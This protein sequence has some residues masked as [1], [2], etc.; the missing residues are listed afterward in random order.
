VS[1]DLGFVHVHRPPQDDDPLTLLLL[2]GTGADERDLLPLGALLA[3]TARKLSPRGKVLEHGM[4]RWFRRHAEGV[5][6]TEDLIARSHELADL[7]PAAAA[8]YGF[9]R[10]AVVAAGFSN[11]ANIAGATM[12]LRPEAFRAA[13]LFAPM[14]PLTVEHLPSL[15]LP[16]L[17]TA[18]VFVAAGR[19]DP[20]CPPEQ[21]E[22]LAGMLHDAGAAV[23]LVW[24]DGG[25]ELTRPVVDAAA[26]WLTDLRHA[27]ATEA[28]DPLP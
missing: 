28:G 3:P 10:S 17:A 15:R 14:L 23:E 1:D 21:A 25:H 26:A 20:I 8:A 16:D 2:H 24:H 22:T 18:A 7:V 5:L 4:P 12:L 27:T 13:L 11:G 19:R 9:D 6:D